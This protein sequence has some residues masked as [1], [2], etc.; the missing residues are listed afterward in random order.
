MNIPLL[1]AWRRAIAADGVWA[2]LDQ[3]ELRAIETT[4]AENGVSVLLEISLWTVSTHMRRTFGKLD[5]RS[6]AEMVAHFFG[7]V[8]AG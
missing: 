5:V 4:A 7:G 3:V 8:E 6:R 2:M 1:I